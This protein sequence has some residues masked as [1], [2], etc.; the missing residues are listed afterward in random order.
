MKYIQLFRKK[1]IERDKDVPYLIRW[2]LFG[3]GKDSSFFSI[4]VHKILVSDFDCLHNH[5]WA[6]MTILLKGSYVETTLIG[7]KP[8]ALAATNGW[9]DLKFCEK[10]LEWTI[11]KKFNA[12]SILY[13]PA[14]W[15]HKL[16]VVDPVWTLVFTFKKVQPWGFLTL[17]G[18]V[19]WSR[20]VKDRDC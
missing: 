9:K 1:V 2:N 6:F 17:K 18:W 15:Y 3:L 13:R 19:H 4:K 16:E 20:F 10:N 14:N 11:N 5:P 12:G 8:F 7:K